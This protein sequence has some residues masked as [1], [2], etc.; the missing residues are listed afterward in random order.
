MAIG[1]MTFVF[2][3]IATLQGVLSGFFFSVAQQYECSLFTS[4]LFRV[5]DTEPLLSQ[6]KYPCVIDRRVAPSIVFDNVSFAYP[7]TERLV[8]RNISL[9]INPGERIALVG[10]NGAGKS[11]LVKLLCRIYDP[12]EGRILVNGRDLREIA[13]P[14]WHSMLGTLFQDYA[15]YHFPVKEVIALGRRDGSVAI[16]LARVRDAARRSGAD[17]FIERWP[18]LYDQMIGREF[19]EGVDPSKGQLQRLALARTF[20]RDARVMIVDEPTSSIDAEAESQILEQ[21]GALSR[22]TTVLLISHRFSN[23]RKADRICVLAGG[24]IRELGTHKD[25]MYNDDIYAKLFKIQADQYSN[26]I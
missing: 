24:M 11:T 13:L 14:Q 9:S 1:T 8:L 26:N 16:D 7:G 18:K 21:F 20:Y 23:L 22:N 2:G 5:L 25:L 3:S 17:S 10:I 6:P 19:S 4:D 12:T 15:S